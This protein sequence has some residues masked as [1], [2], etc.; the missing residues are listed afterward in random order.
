VHFLAWFRSA[1]AQDDFARDWYGYLTN[2]IS[3]I[4]LGIVL[5]LATCIAWFW[6][7]GEYPV[8]W[9]MWLAIT[10]AYAA[11][12][13]IRGGDLW[14]AFEDGCFVC[15]YG[16]GGAFLVFGEVDPGNMDL[17]TDLRTATAIL[18]AAAIHLAIGVGSRVGK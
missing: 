14:D 4:G 6:A 9:A 3:H 16:A 17:I 7:F 5:A 11:S 10:G 15:L 2:Q 12:E 1:F 8:K 18:G 13:V